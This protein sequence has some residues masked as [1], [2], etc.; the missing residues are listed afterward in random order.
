MVLLWYRNNACPQD[1]I[2][3]LNRMD[4]NI[5]PSNFS[6]ELEKTIYDRIDNNTKQVLGSIKCEK[7][8]EVLF[9]GATQTYTKNQKKLVNH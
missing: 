3:G 6:K 7:P 8:I 2:D 1:W 5:V 9:E 4:L